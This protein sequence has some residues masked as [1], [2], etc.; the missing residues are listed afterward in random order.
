MVAQPKKCFTR[1]MIDP[2]RAPSAFAAPRE[3]ICEQ[4]SLHYCGKHL[5]QALRL[6][7]VVGGA[8]FD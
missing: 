3:Y 6:D 2:A 4:K 8:I 1:H 5:K 7:E